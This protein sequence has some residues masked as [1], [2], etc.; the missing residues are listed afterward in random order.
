MKNHFTAISN[1]TLKHL[2]LALILSFFSVLLACK[3]KEDMVTP[4]NQ[5]PGNFI[6]T[7]TL[8]TN[9]QDVV[10]KWTKSKDPEGD[11]VTYSVVYTDTLA[12]NLSDTNFVIKNAL[13]GVVVKGNVVAKDS[14]GAKTLSAFSIQTNSEYVIIPDVNFEKALIQYKIDDVQDGKVLRA[15]V[16]KVTIL[17]ILESGIK[18]LTGIGEFVN[19]K[20]LDCS[21]N[22]LTNLDVGKNI[23]L[24]RL[25][26]SFNQ[27]SNL[28]VGKNIALTFLSC[29]FNQLSNLDVSKNV[30]LNSL[31]CGSNPLTNLDVSK[32]IALTY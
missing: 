21:N 14:K 15:S 20:S 28:D 7:A 8:A 30:V 32:N 19:L 18:D 4:P 3:S 10:L 29:S 12:R 5:P 16:L 26:C 11:V 25:V 22:E 17:S 6:V 9:G 23:A 1:L 2:I 31:G 27:L 13:F 24:T